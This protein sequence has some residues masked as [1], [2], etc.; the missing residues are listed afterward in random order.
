MTDEEI[1]KALEENIFGHAVLSPACGC[2]YLVKEVHA[3][4]AGWFWVRKCFHCCPRHVEELFGLNEF[5]YQP[6][7]RTVD[8]GGVT[9]RAYSDHCINSKAVYGPAK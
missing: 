7:L 9:L 4:H 5:S 6:G 2:F 3:D 1:A 8:G